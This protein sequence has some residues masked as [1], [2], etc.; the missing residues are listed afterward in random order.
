I[1]ARLT[2]R[3]GDA[4]KRLHTGRSRN[5]QVATDL[6]LFVR[7]ELDA[8]LGE[9]ARFRESLA[10][11]AEDEAATVMPGFTHLQAAQPVTLG[12]HLLAYFEMA[13]RDADRLRD[14]RKRL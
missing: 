3:I 6:R 1:E 14:A 11:T 12:H 2:E 10:A 8:I 13:D 4:G 5:D 9:L 7:E